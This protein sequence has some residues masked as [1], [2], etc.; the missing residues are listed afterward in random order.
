MKFHMEYEGQT[1]WIW[2]ERFKGLSPQLQPE[3]VLGFYYIRFIV[4]DQ[5]AFVYMIGQ[6]VTHDVQDTGKAKLAAGPLPS[7]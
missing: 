6:E 7:A 2:D 5:K 4:K 3:E 1:L